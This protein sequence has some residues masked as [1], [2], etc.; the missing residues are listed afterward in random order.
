GGAG[1]GR[2]C[3]ASHEG[4]PG[5][6]RGEIRAGGPV[7]DQFAAEHVSVELHRFFDTGDVERHVVYAGHL[8]AFTGAVV[9]HAD[10]FSSGTVIWSGALERSLWALIDRGDRE[11]TADLRDAC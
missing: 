9:A 10:M 8:R 6:S 4:E 11:G 1:G 5:C 7:G 2:R 3:L